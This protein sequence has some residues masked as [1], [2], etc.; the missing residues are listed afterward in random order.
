[1]QIMS[2]GQQ[3]A[4][5]ISIQVSDRVRCN[6]RCKFCISRTTPGNGTNVDVKTCLPH[7]LKIGLRLAERMGATHAILTGKADPMQ[8][9]IEYLCLLAKQASK[10]MPIVDMHTNGFGFMIK[11]ESFK[12]LVNFGLNMIT[13]SVASFNE[14]DNK[15]L[16]GINQNPQYLIALAKKHNLLIRCSL[17]I[18]KKGVNDI[19]GIMNYI[20]MAGNLGVHMVVIREVWVPEVGRNYDAGVLAWNKENKIPIA[21]LEEEFKKIAKDC[22]NPFGLQRRDPLP[23]GVPVFA[24]GNIFD[25]PDHGVNI[26]F[27]CC[28][29]ANSGPVMKSIVH[30]PNGHGYRNWDH[31]G[32]ILY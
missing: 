32:D 8:E 10:Y 5:S 28:D 13:F 21:P 14:D 6:A 24:I 16:M 31:E 20:Q 23:W 1:M 29:Q 25:N 7:R 26:T 15:E 4:Q 30:K 11:E 3:R 27:A 2:T 17:V 9:N 18:N 19:T 22:H 12:M